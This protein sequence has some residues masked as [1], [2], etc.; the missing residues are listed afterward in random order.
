M[1]VKKAYRISPC[2]GCEE[3]K[4][5]SGC[6]DRCPEYK[7]YKAKIEET[8]KIKAQEYETRGYLMDKYVKSVKR[9]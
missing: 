2:K 3:P 5:Y 4:R 9:R 6:H 8:K 7:E 1:T